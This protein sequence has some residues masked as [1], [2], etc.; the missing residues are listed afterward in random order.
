MESAGK[1]RGLM[2][3]K[4]MSSLYRAACSSQHTKKVKPKHAA[5]SIGYVMNQDI[6]KPQPM[7]NVSYILPTD[8]VM[9]GYSHD[10]MSQLGG[11]FCAVDDERVNMKAANYISCV[12]ERFRVEGINS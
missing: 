12:R 8:D 7:H 10:S 1:R 5:S 3:G 4:L 2:K 11:Y 9:T 6:M